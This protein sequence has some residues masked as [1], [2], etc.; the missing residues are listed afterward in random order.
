MA[1]VFDIWETASK[2]LARTALIRLQSVYSSLKTAE[3]KAANFIL[4]YPEKV[5][6]NNITEAA[7][8]AKCSEATLVRIAK[9]LSYKG[10]PELRAS[11]LRKEAA[12]ILLY[13]GLAAKDTDKDV[14]HK[15]FQASI[16]AIEDSLNI[17]DLNSYNEA[18][19]LLNGTGKV[20]L[21]GSGDALPVALSGCLKFSRA[22]ID[23]RCAYD[24]DTQL[25]QASLMTRGDVVI[26]ISHSGRTRTILDVVKQAKAHDVKII[27]I[28][29]FPVS[30]L[31]KQSDVVLLTAAYL[32]DTMGEVITKRIPELCIV[33]SIYISLTR[34]NSG[35]IAK[36]LE[37]VAVSLESNKL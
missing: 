10:Y 16:R 27:A 15:V 13:T 2:R 35:K 1:K 4:A 6:E 29:N 18:I 14:I 30:P 37:Q 33:E 23:A 36:T 21:V 34:R 26:A 17:L 7:G 31:T 19:D 22:G 12:D 11:I 20:L 3:K 24:F 9:R 25:V 5:A 32:Q 8:M 28:T